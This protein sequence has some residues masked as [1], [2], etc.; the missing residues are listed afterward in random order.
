MTAVSLRSHLP[1]VGDGAG[2]TEWVVHYCESHS[3]ELLLGAIGRLAVHLREK[4]PRGL[5]YRHNRK[6][7]FSSSVRIAR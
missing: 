2:R 6:L 1:P 7:K 3:D 5:L 4:K